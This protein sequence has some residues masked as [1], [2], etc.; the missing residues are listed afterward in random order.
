MSDVETPSEAP[1]APAPTHCRVFVSDGGWFALR[2]D[3]FGSVREAIRHGLDWE[4]TDF[5]GDP[6]Y[7]AADYLRAVTLRHVEHAEARRVEWT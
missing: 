4:G 3:D 1:K 5:Y 6:V 7:F 2:P